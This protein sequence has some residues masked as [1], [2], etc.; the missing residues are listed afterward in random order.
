MSNKAYLGIIAALLLVIFYMATCGRPKPC[1]VITTTHDTS[2]HNSGDSGWVVLDTP[3]HGILP[4]TGEHRLY[5]GS[6]YDVDSVYPVHHEEEAPSIYDVYPKEVVK[7]YPVHDTIYGKIDTAEVLKYFFEKRAYTGSAYLDDAHHEYGKVSVR[8]SVSQNQITLREWK[9]ELHLPIIK[10]TRSDT[11]LI[12]KQHFQVYFGGTVLGSSGTWLSGV[13][14]K[15]AFK[16]KG[17]KLYDFSFMFG[18]G[19]QKMIQAGALIKIGRK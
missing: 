14:P 7:W 8:E 13:G 6:Y 5:H 11:I 10:E 17:D 1:P 2:Y 4:D 15:V 12:E 16:T 9:R 3:Y 19:G 18:P